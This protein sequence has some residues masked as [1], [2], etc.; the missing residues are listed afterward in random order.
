MADP[1][2]QNDIRTLASHLDLIEDVVAQPGGEDH[3]SMVNDL[4]REC[5][6]VRQRLEDAVLV[7]LEQE[8]SRS[9]DQISA[10]LERLERIQ[11]QVRSGTAGGGARSPP[12]AAFQPP[13]QTPQSPMWQEPPQELSR[14][15]SGSPMA[16]HA[17]SSDPDAFGQAARQNSGLSD[18]QSSKKKKKEKKEKRGADSVPEDFGFPNSSGGAG[19]DTAGGWPAATSSSAD[20]FGSGGAAGDAGG[21]FDMGG[22]G[23]STGGF[24]DGG[25]GGGGGWGGDF[26]A[27][28][29][30]AGSSGGGAG[31]NASGFGNTG[32]PSGFGAPAPS[33]FGTAFGEEPRPPQSRGSP[34]LGAG[35]SGFFGS[36]V[37]PEVDAAPV[38]TAPG[39]FS[40]FGS[41]SFGGGFGSQGQQASF[42]IKGVP[43]SEVEHD[44]DAFERLFVRAAARAAGVPQHRIRVKAIRAGHS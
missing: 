34:Q 35:T 6:D 11:E 24:G 2:V 44:R 27:Q 4:L 19:F 12:A 3:A 15:P 38:D 13:A 40:G 39:R 5:G 30:S 31:A 21:G 8:D 10:V 29:G 7:V 16:S 36:A 17:A 1:S 14:R 43:F 41:G 26:D 42:Q 18:M 28:P 33:A 9:F 22:W 32:S 23:S 25:A 37:E 20:A